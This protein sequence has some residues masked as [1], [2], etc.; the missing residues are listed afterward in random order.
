M[1]AVKT[2]PPRITAPDSSGRGPGHKLPTGGGGEGEFSNRPPEH[3]DPRERLSRARVGLAILLTTSLGLFVTLS[4]F[5]VFLR[6][7]TVFDPVTFS[8]VSIW[9]PIA[10]PPLLWWNTGLLI[11]SSIALEFARRAYFREDLIM[12]E[13]LG[14]SRPTLARAV[15]WEA[16]SFFWLPASLLGSSTPGANS[17]RRA[18]SWVPG[19]AASFTTF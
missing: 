5:Y 9:H 19:R 17:A 7:Q 15:P 18:Y 3:R 10:I 2:P 1:P 16:V 14:L 6:R 8:Y 4:L 11:L 12:D 13:W